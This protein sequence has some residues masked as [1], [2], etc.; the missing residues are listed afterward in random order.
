MRNAPS[1]TMC[2]P[3]ATPCSSSISSSRSRPGRSAASE[4]HPRPWVRDDLLLA[5]T[6]HRR[7]GHGQAEARA[8]RSGT[9]A[10]AD[11]PGR[12]APSA[13][14]SSTRTP[15]V[16]ELTS[17]SRP[18]R[19]TVPWN[20][21]PGMAASVIRTGVLG[22]SC[23]ASR[24]K[25]CTDSQTRRRLA[26]RN[27][28]CEACASRTTALPLQHGS[29]HRR[30]EHEA[31]GSSDAGRRGS[32]PSARRADVMERTAACASAVRSRPVGVRAATMRSAASAALAIDG[33][34]S[35]LRPSVGAHQ[36]AA[37]GPAP[38]CAARPAY[39]PRAPHCFDRPTSRT[40]CASIG[41]ATGV[42]VPIHVH[43]AQHVD[44]GACGSLLHTSSRHAKVAQHRSVDA[45]QIGRI[46][47]ALDIR[48][49]RGGCLL[50]RRL[51][52]PARDERGTTLTHARA[53]IDSSQYSSGGIDLDPRPRP[54]RSMHPHTPA[55]RGWTSCRTSRNSM[56]LSCPASRPR[57]ASCSLSGR[58]EGRRRARRPP[59]PGVGCRWPV[60][61][62]R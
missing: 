11:M 3:A 50:C 15:S 12:R 36:L 62:A 17:T 2:S 41:G 31:R 10:V 6:L 35:Q 45:D 4:T 27:I 21:R 38:D 1:T 23:T 37:L 22:A 57:E 48:L 13:L 7:G 25:A 58:A 20:S 49:R 24:S 61:R 60:R 53:A 39:R 29:G 26:I 28:G 59:P 47:V 14:G 8:A 52:P 43:L 46:A 51:T 42:G 44:L 32:A 5:N 55:A 19:A 18:T 34:G 40:T 33:A 56:R 16:R 9:C 54:P 30:P